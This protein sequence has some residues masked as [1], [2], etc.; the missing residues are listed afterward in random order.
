MTENQNP[1]Y[2]KK[3]DGKVT[4]IERVTDG[5]KAIPPIL[6]C[7]A[8]AYLLD[9]SGYISNVAEILPANNL[10][11]GYHLAAGSGL[12]GGYTSKENRKIA[13][14]VILASSFIPEI[15]MFTQD[16]NL[17]SVGT[18]SAT[19]LIGYE[20]GYIIGYIFGE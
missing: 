16:G 6:G 20:V 11:L 4:L 10:N 2:V 15:I 7:T 14:L 8:G 3:E 1:Q 18:T 12:Y 9:F 19:K 5:L 13:S 17:R